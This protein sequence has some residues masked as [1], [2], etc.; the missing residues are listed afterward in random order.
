MTFP[1]SMYY[2]LWFLLFGVIPLIA[3]LFQHESLTAEHF[4]LLFV[5]GAGLIV[6]CKSL[7]TAW[8]KPFDLFIGIVFFALGLLGILHNFGLN[9]TSDNAHIPIGA[10]SS[11]SFLGISLALKA[12]LLHTL[13]GFLSISFGIKSPN[14]VSSLSVST[15][16]KG[17]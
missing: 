13:L 17:G 12:S 1:R 14:M 2:W 5:G 11:A 3:A 6:G 10:V 7:A 8:S 9:L 16:E 15:A 4:W